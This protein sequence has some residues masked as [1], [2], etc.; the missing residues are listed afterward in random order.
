LAILLDRL[1]R[2]QLIA[3]LYTLLAPLRLIGVSRERAA[4]R[5]A[6]TLQYAE[7]AM[8]RK[9]NSWQDNLHGLFEPQE[10]AGKKMELTLYR[11]GINDGLLVG[12]ALLLL[13][14]TLR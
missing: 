3:G 2:Q 6:L 1:H 14:W 13:F 5:L 9:T 12:F 10:E 4:V 11:F 7:A 8:L